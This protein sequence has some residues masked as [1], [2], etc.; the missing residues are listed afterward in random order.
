MMLVKDL[1]NE[2]QKHNPDAKVVSITV[3]NQ[4]DWEYTSEP[5]I[6]TSKNMSGEKVWIQ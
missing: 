4:N 5:K 3:G 6:T 2:L 1:I